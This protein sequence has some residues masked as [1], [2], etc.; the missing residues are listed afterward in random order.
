MCRVSH[1]L[2]GSKYG[3]IQIT[4]RAM[5]AWGL[6]WR[7]LRM[8]LKMGPFRHKIRERRQDL[9]FAKCPSLSKG[10]SVGESVSRRMVCLSSGWYFSMGV[11]GI[12]MGVTYSLRAD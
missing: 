8:R 11:Y 7:I 9:N 3:G 1:W 2:F 12:R 4:L 6:V 5:S 10:R